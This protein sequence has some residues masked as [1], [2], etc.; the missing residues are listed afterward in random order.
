[1]GVG[2]KERKNFFSSLAIEF[3]EQRIFWC[4]TIAKSVKEGKIKMKK[5]QQQNAFSI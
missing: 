5:Q 3:G 1:V 4:W 2:M